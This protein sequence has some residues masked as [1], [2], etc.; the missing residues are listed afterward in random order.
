M[1]QLSTP[2]GITTDVPETLEED[3]SPRFYVKTDNEAA[4]K[5]YN[6]NGYVIFK[7]CISK[8]NCDKLRNLW[9]KYVKPYKGKIYRQT[10]AKAE[11]NKFNN[12]NWVMNPILNLQSLNPTLFGELKHAV[13]TEVF[14]N[15]YVCKALKLILGERP[16]IVQ[17]MYFEGN[18]ATWEHQD[19][20]YLDS[21]QVGKMTAAWFPDYLGLEEPICILLIMNPSTFLINRF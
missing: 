11:K 20:Y 7:D 13:E 17:S 15:D 2:N 19:T 1:I 9:E 8:G 16:K 6:N 14:S 21:E 18:S 10:T 4:V 3:N 5:Y 12:N